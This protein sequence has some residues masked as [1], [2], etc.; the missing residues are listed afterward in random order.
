MSWRPKEW[1][2][3]YKTS[4]ILPYS[5]CH[6]ALYYEQDK[7]EKQGYH[8]VRSDSEGYH[9]ERWPEYNQAFELGA[10]AILAALFKMAKESPT[11]T[12]TI[13]SQTVTI[14]EAK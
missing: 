4:V 5:V 13:D 7:L 1:N 11:G 2:N 6:E 12:F 10:D 8:F 14:Y 3:P 9:Y